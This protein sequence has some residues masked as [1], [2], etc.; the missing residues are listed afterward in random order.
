MADADSGSDVKHRMT[1]SDVNVDLG[2]QMQPGFWPSRGRRSMYEDMQPLSEKS[3]ILL[4]YWRSEGVRN[5][6]E[7][8]HN[9]NTV[10]LRSIVAVPVRN[11]RT[12]TSTWR[13]TLAKV[14]HSS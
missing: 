12:A 10:R 9:M 2:N 8:C 6:S 11:I 3:R 4:P 1:R 7:L 13:V 14:R 5:V